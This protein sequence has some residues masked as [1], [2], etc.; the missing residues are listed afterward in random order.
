MDRAEGDPAKGAE[1][2]TRVLDLLT[3][4]PELNEFKHTSVPR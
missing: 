4:W 3:G 2:I 1:T